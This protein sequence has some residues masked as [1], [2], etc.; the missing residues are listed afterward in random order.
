MAKKFFSVFLICLL[1]CVMVSEHS[2]QGLMVTSDKA[3][4][5][6]I[7]WVDFDIT[8]EALEDAMNVDIETY[9]QDL[10]VSWVDILAFLACK[11]G[12]DFSMYSHKDIDWFVET[13][14][15]GSSV[16]DIT[17]NMKS[18]PYY[19]K[20]YCAVIGNFLGLDKDGNYG[21][22]AYSPV[23]EGYWYTD[24]DD[25]GNGRSYGFARKHLGHDMFCSVGTPVAAVE[26]GKVEA[27]GWNQY[28]G[29]RIGIRSNDGFRYYYY[30]HLR[31]DSPYIKDLKEGD[32]VKAGQ[33]IGY[34]GQ[35][36]YS[37]K[38][39]V[40]NI[41]VPH[42]HFGMQ[43]VFDE[44]QKE[45]NS[46]IWIDTYA[47]IRLLSKHRASPEIKETAKTAAATAQVPILMY[48]GL[49][50]KQSQVND[51]FIPATTFESDMK[52]LKENGYTA[53]TMTELIDYVYDKTGKIALPEK[54]VVI[55]FD[56]GYCNNYNYATP[57]LEKYGM[58]AVLSVIGHAC[59]EASVADHRAEDYCNV[60]WDQI[61]E[62][63]DSGLWEI[64]N[65]TWDS[66]EAKG[67]RKGASKKEWESEDVYEKILKEDLSILQKKLK[68]TTGVYPNTFTWPF[69]AYTEDSRDLLKSMGFK[70][71]L[72]CNGGI[73]TIEKGDT[74]GL[75][76][77]K[78]KL[79]TPKASIA[80]LLQ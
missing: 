28:G 57:A 4:K 15:E 31:K 79:R 59:E 61:K 1:V 70:A 74:E 5:D 46:E 69:G 9:E 48:H 21:L 43:L 42:L 32:T 34:S 72:S 24:S 8:Y 63:S 60:T 41:N 7:K 26:G 54:P 76:L 25:F 56:D 40:N 52:Y 11:Y 19:Y 55:T 18:Y 47:L 44:S 78:R 22:T 67:G 64:Q 49:T 29:W 6:Y 39:N 27:L 37:V 38:E 20:A 45:C 68:E 36:G 2:V 17:S 35:S 33:I 62:M 75:Y 10:H 13:L 51:Y 71:T 73:N 77:L 16:E 80:E 66:H 12:G 30:A 65:H 23:A 50:K 53:I 14:N 3:N 58:K